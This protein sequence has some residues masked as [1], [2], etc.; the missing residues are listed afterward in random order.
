[1]KKRY[2]ILFI[3]LF[4][5]I[6]MQ[7]VLAS[8]P[9]QPTM[10]D[11]VV[12]TTSRFAE[13]KK[14]VS[15]N[16][17]LIDREELDQSVSR[18]VGDLIAEKGIGHIQKYPGNL[19]SVSI[20]GFRSDTHGN[21][22]RGHVLIL[23]DGRRAGTGNVAKILTKNVERIEIIRGPGAV[24]YGSAG[25]GGV[26]NVITR[27]GKKN[28]LFIEAGG[29]SFG[30][31]EGSIGGTIKENNFDF[32]GSFTYQLRDDYDTSGGDSYSNTGISYGT[33][34]SANLGYSF[35][36]KH[37]LGLILTGFSVKEA[38]NPGY[39][40]VTDSDDTSDKDNYSVDLQYTGSSKQY[41]WMLRYFLGKDENSWLDPI[42]SNPTIWDDG[43]A[44]T[45]ETDQQGA[46][47]QVSRVFGNSTLTAGI[48][49]LDYEVE[50]SW[51]P[52]KTS[53]SNPALFLLAKTAL[54]DGRIVANLGLRYDWYTVQVK[55]PAGRDED[56]N[57]L[58]PKIG[59]AWMVNDNLKLRA[60][61]AQGFMLPSADQLA[62][63]YS[64]FGGMVVG[65]SD[66]DPEKS[67]TYEGGLEYDRNGFQASLTY[68]HTDFE[69]K[70]VTDYLISG[71]QS[72]K[73]LGD[74]TLSGL[75]T[76]LSYDIG[77][78]LD[79]NWEIRPFFNLTLFTTYEDDTT[80]DNLL[81]ISD[82]NLSTG[83]VVGNG[84]GFSCRLNITYS[85]SQ[86]V[87]DWES[88][89]YPAPVVELDSHLVADLSASYRIFESDNWGALTM[90]GELKNI[91]DEEYAYVKGY[92]MPGRSIFFGLRWEY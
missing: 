27:R 55:E 73:N 8:E 3:Q 21:D 81:Y 62:A 32:A 91:F 77:T 86:D 35:S 18:N 74:A 79:S 14:E 39:F 50:N 80:G 17:T 25:M 54:L 53:Y 59:V 22:L 33:G 49:W 1:M 89:A 43:V 45:N 66:L 64:S 30:T 51:T 29:G 5:C 23:L 7:S 46:Q 34:Y 61:Y 76:G 69:D 92:P 78:L 24:Q 44:S 31:G 56:Q 26:V 13:T 71:S 58:T 75:E 4:T 38:G 72:W 83:L 37:R 63:N 52:K 70:I 60:Q 84:D 85:G 36:E 87:E 10:L 2:P 40:S 57:R 42:A 15:A 16:V 11:K 12:V 48:D 68:F 19:T 41:Q 47:A 90:R 20:R 9:P 67:S 6:S 65:N 88:G 28:S 82:T